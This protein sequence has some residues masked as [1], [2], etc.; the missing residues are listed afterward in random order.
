MPAKEV[1]VDEGWWPDI[2][3]AAV[4][5]WSSGP[6]LS[7]ALIVLTVVSGLLPTAMVWVGKLIVDAVVAHD[8][9][10][11]TRAL[12]MEAAFTV[13]ATAA[14]VGNGLAQGLLRTQLGHRVNRSILD[15]VLTLDLSH[16]E[17][18]AFYDSLTRARREASTRPLSMVRRLLTF[19]Q[20]GLA[21]LGSASLLVRFSWG[22][23]AVLLVVAAPNFIHQTRFAKEGF[24]LFNWRSPDSREQAYY[25]TVLTREDYAKEV[26]LY[27]LGDWFLD[28]YQAIYDRLAGED[29]RLAIRRESVGLGLSL[30][31]VAV[32]YGVYA[33]IAW[34]AVQGRIGI[35]DMTLY[36]MA[37]RQGQGTLSGLV[38][39]ASG[40]VEDRLYLS[41]L[42]TFLATPVRAR[43]GSAKVGPI[44]GDGIRFEDVSFAY[45]GATRAALADITL[46]LRPGS[47]LALVGPN[48]SGKSTLIKLLTRLYEPTRGRVTLDGLD[49]REWDHGALR[50]RIG[51]VMQ[52][53]ARYQLT[54][55]DNIGLGDLTR[56]DLPGAR[57][58]AAERGL[59]SDVVKELPAGLETRLGQWFKGGVDL[60][61]GQWQ[62]IAL[63]RAFLRI[64]ADLLVLDEPT[65]AMDADAEAQLFVRLREAAVGRMAIL[66]SH[67]F[68][69][70]RLAD[71]ILVI[72]GG[73]I[74][75]R[76]SHEALM[77]SGGTYARLFTLQAAGYR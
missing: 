4:L 2:R 17:D 64:D 25:E 3:R 28:R 49:L 15:K 51:A 48:G 10:A 33:W 39:A 66:I 27:G 29:R 57:E 11:A 30:V 68:S 50:Q 8:V 14:S 36:L 55:G 9:A 23:A 71:E 74:Q 42:A 13:L 7:V 70:V 19:V 73:R 77:A 62:R 18:A 63:A 34:D 59:A 69:T 22:A 21:L 65:S 35:G 37:F 20:L 41:T 26:M 56:A 12:L 6:G 40:L 5:V 46:H 72:D 60:S 54:A 61:G 45:P 52:D 75:E 76:G 31:G 43:T 1:A 38:Q 58:A 47:A 53:F 16:F 67:R 24:R 32:F 44:P